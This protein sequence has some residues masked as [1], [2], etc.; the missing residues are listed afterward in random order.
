MTSQCLL[1]AHREL[2]TEASAENE[3][4][5]DGLPSRARGD[6]SKGCV[7]CWDC[8]ALVSISGDSR[9][10]KSVSTVPISEIFLQVKR[11]STGR[12]Q[13]LRKLH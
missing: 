4:A 12:V 1:A 6:H 9:L 8:V 3:I 11:S 5:G 2:G 13:T 7:G 10:A